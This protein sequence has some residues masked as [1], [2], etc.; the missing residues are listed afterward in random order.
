MKDPTQ[1]I[2]VKQK[3]A[4]GW[5]KE[6]SACLISMS[7]TKNNFKI[8]INKAGNTAQVVWSSIPSSPSP[9]KIFNKK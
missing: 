4:R 3:R 2:T 1:K 5:L 9:K 6:L 8:L 7:S